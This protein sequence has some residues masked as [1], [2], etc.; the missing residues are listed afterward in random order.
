MTDVAPEQGFDFAA[1]VAENARLRQ[2][3]L[4]EN[5]RLKAALQASVDQNTGITGLTDE[6]VRRIEHPEE[7]LSAENEEFAQKLAD[8]EAKL[9]SVSS[10]S[11]DPSF[12][13]KADVTPAPDAAPFTDNGDGTWTR[14]SDGARGSFGPNGFS[15]S[16]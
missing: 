14:T 11:A 16:V 4:T 5:E 9:A 2:E 1:V 6:D 7:F 10:R 13:N 15:A 8:L 3:L 12:S